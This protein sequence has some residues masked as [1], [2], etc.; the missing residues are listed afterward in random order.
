MSKEISN[1]IKLGFFV[2]AGMIALVVSMYLIGKNQNLFGTN[3]KLKARFKDISGLTS[4]NNVR[5]SG[6]GAGTVNSIRIIGD[7]CIE[8]GLIIDKKLQKFIHKNAIVDIGNEGLMGNKVVNITPNSAPDV[9]VEDGDLLQSKAE[10]NTGSMLETFSHTNDNV[11]VIS[12]DLKIAL[13]RLN[14]SKALWSVLED[15]SLTKDIKITLSN[16]RRSSET[17]NSTTADLHQLIQSVKK[18]E[19]IAGVLFSDKKEAENLKSTIA[20][21][22][23][24]AANTDK[25]MTKLNNIANDIQINLTHGKGTIPTLLNDTT[26]SARINNSIFNFQQSSTSLK[27]EIEAL[28]QNHF[29]KKY[30]K[31]D[32]EQKKKKK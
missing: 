15:S 22:E 9:E 26:T 20:N 1:N 19:G 30:L 5:F 25:L 14:N 27:E 28:K 31:K 12:S 29:M 16:F 4:G 23:K 17:F 24:I 18:G 3:F 2:I 6:I 21:L 7:T 11:E 13:R 10:V 32:A 8:I